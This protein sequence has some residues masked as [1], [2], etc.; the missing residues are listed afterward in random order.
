MGSDERRNDCY[1]IH[2]MPILRSKLCILAIAA[3]VLTS[4]T[5]PPP[6]P[7]GKVTLTVTVSA[8]LGKTAAFRFIANGD[9]KTKGSK[10]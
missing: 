10:D 7:V 2:T 1:A 5:P 9:Y 6:A 4:C 8:V 3:S